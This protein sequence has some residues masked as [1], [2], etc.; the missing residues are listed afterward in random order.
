MRAPLLL[1]MAA[2]S[3]PAPPTPT[4]PPPARSVPE[5]SGPPPIAHVDQP[6]RIEQL[7]LSPARPTIREDLSAVVKSSDPEGSWV[8][9]HYKW[10]V[11]DHELYHRT[12]DRLPKS[13]LKKGDVVVLAVEVSDGTNSVERALPPV[14]IAN[15][16]PIWLTDPRTMKEV[17]GKRLQAQ[18]PDGDPVNY[19]LEGAPAGMN[20]DSK[21]GLLTYKGS[22]DAEAGDYQIAVIAEDDDGGSV[23]WNFGISV[24]AGS[25]G[26]KP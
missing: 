22:E 21:G 12:A 17:I 16:D 7:Q 6:P 26:G 3:D 14:T 11:N 1:L 23:R 18:D 5:K 20:I 2:C 25:K 4:E 10:T 15:S 13:E 19:R 9:T 8:D 24:S